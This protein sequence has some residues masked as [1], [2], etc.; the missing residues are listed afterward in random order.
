MTP[1]HTIPNAEIQK[2]RPYIARKL[3]ISFASIPVCSSSLRQTCESI[4]KPITNQM[5]TRYPS[6][7]AIIENASVYSTFIWGMRAIPI[8]KRIHANILAIYMNSRLGR[9]GKNKSDTGTSAKNKNVISV[10]SPV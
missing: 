7:R 4:I 6:G 2:I 10:N 5:S 1:Y 8:A 9:V 3:K